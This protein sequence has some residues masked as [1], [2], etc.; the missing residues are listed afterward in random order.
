MPFI[1]W[2]SLSEKLKK[3][4]MPYLFIMLFD[5]SMTFSWGV[6]VLR[7]IARSSEFVKCSGPLLISFS[8]GCES[9]GKSFIF[10]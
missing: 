2:S 3:F 1:S 7:M 8:L 4:D 6:P 5:I 9:F 10:I